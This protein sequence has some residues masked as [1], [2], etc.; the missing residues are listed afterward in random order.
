MSASTED[1]AFEAASHS[2]GHSPLRCGMFATTWTKP[3]LNLNRGRLVIMPDRQPYTARFPVFEVPTV[4]F[5]CAT[6]CTTPPDT[7][8][9]EGR[10]H[11][12]SWLC[13][14]G[15]KFLQPPGPAHQ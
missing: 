9:C 4:L 14:P 5:R 13:P 1:F 2:A 3:Y 6:R 15:G 8:T 12:Y 11:S 10:Y 7:R